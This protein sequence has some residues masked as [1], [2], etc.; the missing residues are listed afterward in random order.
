VQSFPFA[1]KFPLAKQKMPFLAVMETVRVPRKVVT[2]DDLTEFLDT[3]DEW[4]YTR[5]GIRKRHVLTDE[6]L[7][8]LAVGSAEI[9]LE[10]A[11]TSPSE[12]GFVLAATMRG[13]TVTPSFAF[14][15]AEKLG[16][17]APAFDVN[18]ACVGVLY[19]MELADS[20]IS[21]GKADK[22]L[23]VSAEAMS[24]LV[25]WNDRALFG[26][27]VQKHHDRSRAHVAVFGNVHEHF[28]LFY[29]KLF[30]TGVHDA[31]VRLMREEPVHFRRLFTHK[32]E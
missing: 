22:I 14:C 17:A 19:C 12:I 6:T 30:L 5:T 27:F 24:K 21:T 20:L 25:D 1:F 18:A 15:V 11:K 8:D 9:A 23:I 31:H 29:F 7:L 32:M 2:N 26:K 16:I 28:A 10:D 4:I 13:D 3:S